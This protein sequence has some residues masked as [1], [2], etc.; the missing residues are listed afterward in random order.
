MVDAFW[1]VASGYN[2]PMRVANLKYGAVKMPCD[3]SEMLQ[4]QFYFFGTYFV[5]EDILDCWREAAKGAKMIFDVGANDGIYSVAA[6]AIEPDTIIHAFEP[7]PEIAARL[8]ETAKLNGLKQ[9][10][11]HEVAV[12]SVSGHATLRR[13]RGRTGTNEG[14]NFID[15]D[16]GAAGE[17][18]STV[19][20][21]QFCKRFAIRHIDLLNLDIEGYEHLALKGAEHLIRG[22]HVGTIFMELNWGTGAACGASESI[23]LL[24]EAGY[25]FAKPGKRLHWRKSGVWLRALTDV[26]ARRTHLTRAS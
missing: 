15:A 9:L 3:L 11:V 13:C 6:L 23:S 16:L 8:R 18:V 26:V 5:E 10:H 12:S 22:G 4:R 20:L 21:D 1:R 24:Q 7:R 2:N 19:C 17:R 25:S 14:M